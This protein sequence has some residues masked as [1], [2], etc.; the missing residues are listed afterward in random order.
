[1]HSLRVAERVSVTRAFTM[2]QSVSS[3]IAKPRAF[4]MEKTAWPAQPVFDLAYNPEEIKFRL[5][6]IPVYTVIN[7]AKEF[8]LV[9]GEVRIH[10]ALVLSMPGRAC[11]AS[12]S[13]EV[14]IVRRARGSSSA[15]SSSHRR[16]PRR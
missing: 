13:A 10:G 8:V 4:A 9:S 2:L 7:K 11:V 3:C 12:C 16:T 15:C 5:S 14:N 1:M 6:G